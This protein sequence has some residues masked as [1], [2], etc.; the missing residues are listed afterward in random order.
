MRTAVIRVDVDPD[1]GL[2]PEQL[3]AGLETL[4]TLAGAAGAKVVDNGLPALPRG[5]REAELLMDG[6]DAEELMAAAMAMCT[7]AFGTEPLPGVVTYVSRGTDEDAHGVLAGF[8]ITGEITRTGGD[9]GFDILHVTMRKADASRVGE[10]RIH[11]ALQASTN[12]E[13]Y[14]RT[15]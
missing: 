14:I 7:Q 1:G 12:C 8:G 2:S 10:S 15:V 6:A 5:R 13:V 9:D 11:T 4:R 3:A